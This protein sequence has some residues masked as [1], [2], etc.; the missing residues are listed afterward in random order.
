MTHLVDQYGL[1]FL[2]VIVAL[3]SAGAWLPGETALIA[4]AVLASQGQFP[5]SAVVAIA[6]A[7]AILGDNLGYWIGRTF[8]RGI[9]ERFERVRRLLPRAERFFAK[10]GGKAVF[11][12]RFIA[13][14]RVTA[15]W[16][17]GVG[18]M[19]WWRFLFWNAC[20]GIA[21]AIGIGVLAYYAGRA[22][23]DA[24]SQYGLY[25]AAGV[26]AVALVVLVAVRLWG[27]RALG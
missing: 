22:A 20:G 7:A 5:L 23:A 27:H 6:A 19:P 11:L 18:Q 26:V 25:G 9:L 3:E 21:W 12:A 15:A 17:A 2:F 1:A 10:H 8:G 4:A 14:L 24:A 16:M 13:G